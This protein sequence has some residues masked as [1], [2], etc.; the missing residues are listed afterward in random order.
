MNI[1]EYTVPK[2]ST[3]RQSVDELA[4]RSIGMLLENIDSVRS[5]RYET[6]STEVER[7]ESTRSIR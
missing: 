5:P 3:V 1:G 7:K 4:K 2:L 6:I